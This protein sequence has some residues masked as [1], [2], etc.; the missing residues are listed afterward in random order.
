MRVGKRNDSE[1]N[2]R[3][4]FR[5]ALPTKQKREKNANTIHS[6]NQ[7]QIPMPFFEDS[8]FFSFSLCFYL[9]FFS[10]DDFFSIC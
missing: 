5:N 7:S 6:W 8:E 4:Y 2:G 10:G 1:L 9:D 3:K